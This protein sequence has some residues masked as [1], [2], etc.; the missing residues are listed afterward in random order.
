MTGG[1][2]RGG[3]RGGG[4]GGFKKGYA[5]KRSPGDDDDAPR[6]SK[7]SKGDDDEEEDAAPVVPKLK[8]DEDNNPFIALN[9]SGK[10]RVTVSDFKGMTLVSIREYWVN[11]GGELKPGKKGISLSIEQYNALLAS[12]PLLESV[13]SKKDVQVARPNY[14]ADLNALKPAEEEKEEGQQSIAKVYDDENEE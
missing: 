8:T 4:G 1:F 10:R 14:E 6:A 12:A 11:D 5:K 3:I 2:K 7:K 9:H 13:L